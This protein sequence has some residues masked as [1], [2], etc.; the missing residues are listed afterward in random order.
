MTTSEQALTQPQAPPQ[1]STGVPVARIENLEH[2]DLED[3]LPRVHAMLAKGARLVTITCVDVGG[4]FEVI[5]HFDIDLFMTHL[6]VR[7]PADQKL[8]SI[9]GEYLCAFL[10]EN[11]I[12]DLFG[13]QVDGLPVDYRGR[14]VLTEDSPDRPLLRQR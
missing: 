10:V 7:V 1:V 4:A 9:T 13:L 6:S 12:C 2:I 5:Y 14:L 11:E 3:L 8:P